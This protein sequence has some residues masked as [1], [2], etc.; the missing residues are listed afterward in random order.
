MNR[1]EIV[2]KK[3]SLK[4]KIPPV[5][6]PPVELEYGCIWEKCP[7]CPKDEKISMVEGCEHY[8]G[9]GYC[10]SEKYGERL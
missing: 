6:S 5:L 1:Y 2:L 7:L 4:A 9:L 8:I 3:P 10:A